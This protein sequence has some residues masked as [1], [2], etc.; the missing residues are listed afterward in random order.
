[1]K[2]EFDTRAGGAG[3]L[4]GAGG[5]RFEDGS[6]CSD[7]LLRASD[8][9]LRLVKLY[10]AVGAVLKDGSP[11]CGV[12]YVYCEGRRVPGRGVAAERLIREGYEVRTVDSLQGQ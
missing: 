8:E 4:D 9:V 6:D 5:A 2:I 12:S 3:L 11:S 1:M 7:I 10:G